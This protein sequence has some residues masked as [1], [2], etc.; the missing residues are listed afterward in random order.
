MKIFTVIFNGFSN[1]FRISATNKEDAEK[2]AKQITSNRI[3][4]IHEGDVR[5]NYI[6]EKDKGMASVLKKK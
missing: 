1:L 3:D 2:R 4:E 5:D 6:K